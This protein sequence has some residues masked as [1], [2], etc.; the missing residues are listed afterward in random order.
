MLSKLDIAVI[1]GCPPAE[2]SHSLF[3]RKKSKRRITRLG[4]PGQKALGGL[5]E[6]RYGR[7]QAA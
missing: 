1:I 3:P 5:V 2:R 4:G 7:L 6:R